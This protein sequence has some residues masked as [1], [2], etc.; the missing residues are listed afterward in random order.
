MIRA[1]SDQG[2]GE[3]W[4]WMAKTFENKGNINPR[5]ASY[6]RT[7][8]KAKQT[9]RNRPKGAR[10]S[11]FGWW[12]ITENLYS[13]FQLQQFS[14]DKK[15]TWSMWSTLFLGRG[16]ILDSMISLTTLWSHFTIF[17]L[18]DN[19]HSK[20]LLDFLERTWYSNAAELGYWLS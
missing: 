7:A 5:N 1:H 14:W 13:R 17:P 3:I 6:P 15:A 9:A 4:R 16:T 12:I 11:W 2:V 20:L 19:M 8:L 10:I 18:Q